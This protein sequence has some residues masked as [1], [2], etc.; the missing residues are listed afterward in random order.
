MLSDEHKRGEAYLTSCQTVACDMQEGCSKVLLH[1]PEQLLLPAKIV[2]CTARAQAPVLPSISVLLE[3]SSVLVVSLLP[4][5]LRPTA[6]G[7]ETSSMSLAS[8]R[9]L[10]Q[11]SHCWHCT[12]TVPL[13]QA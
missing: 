8:S 1:S 3:V 6:P 7:P 4:S 2:H 5:L 10:C 11:T 13:A 9:I 12:N